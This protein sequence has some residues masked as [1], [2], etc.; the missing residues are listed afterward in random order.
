MCLLLDAKTNP[1]SSVTRQ[2][3]GVPGKLTG[4][5]VCFGVLFRVCIG[6]DWVCF[7]FFNCQFLWIRFLWKKSVFRIILSSPYGANVEELYLVHLKFIQYLGISFFRSLEVFFFFCP[8]G[9]SMFHNSYISDGTGRVKMHRL[10]ILGFSYFFW[11]SEHKNIII[12]K[13]EY[14]TFR[15]LSVKNKQLTRSIPNC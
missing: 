5:L 14:N 12:E 7:A 4:R 11:V 2:L 9:H 13:I 15:C 8:R 10:I 3:S 6:Y 1:F